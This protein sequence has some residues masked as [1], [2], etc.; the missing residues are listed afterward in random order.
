MRYETSALALLLLAGTARA[1]GTVRPNG[2][3]ARGVGMGGAWAAWVDD[4]T[5]IWFNPGALDAVDPHVMLGAEVVL[6]PRRYTPTLPD[7][8]EGEPQS[9][10]IA[11][12]VPT[13][14]VVGR[15]NYQDE[16]SRFT[17]GFGV[18]N[19]LG[20]QVSYEKTGMPALDATQDLC[21]EIN[22]GA[23]LHV[24]DRFSIGAAARFGLGFFHIEATQNPFDADLSASG[25]G[26]GMTVGALFRPTET[27]RIGVTW[28]SPLRI[29]TT[30][31]GTVDQGGLISRP[32]V[33]HE[34]NWPQQAA[35]GLGW[36]ATPRWKLATELDWSQWSQTDRI[37]VVF[38]NGELPDQSYAEYWHDNWSARLGGEYAVSRGVQLRAGTYYDS[39]AVPDISL[40]RQ[41]SDSHKFGVSLGASLHA[42]GW[43]FDLAADGIIPAT[44]TV[45]NNAGDVMGVP[46]LQN[47]APGDYIGSLITF[48]LAAARRF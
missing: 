47:K 17:F 11:A 46:A 42:A 39:P 7:G 48:E 8:T 32:D 18:W 19:T 36:Q 10:L 26:V 44:R 14:G 29:A 24:S 40:E 33:S 30:G 3:S 34:Q 21:I 1:G 38:P 16:P 41:Y 2:I 12:P 5:A 37:E 43:R 27:V 15:F 20:G 6:G 9:T 13:L 25:V 4:A 28:R 45:P 23:S 22:G 35:L 31:S